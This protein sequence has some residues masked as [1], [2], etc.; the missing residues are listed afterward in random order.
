MVLKGVNIN[1]YKAF[2]KRLSLVIL[3]LMAKISLIAAMAKHRVIGYQNRLPWRLPADMKWFK[4]HTIGKPIVMGRKTWESIGKPLPGRKNIVITR[5]KNYQAPGC[6]VIA[7]LKKVNEVVEDAEEIMIIGGA[8][9]YEQ[10][11]PLANKLYLTFID[12]EFKGDTFFPEVDMADWKLVFQQSHL[13]DEQN[14]YPYQFLI[15][16][17]LC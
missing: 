6:K 11:L 17:L 16:E 3:S 9:L 2:C 7:N 4:Q 14:P 8:K 1:S 13:P 10:A 5:Q 15:Y 12:Q